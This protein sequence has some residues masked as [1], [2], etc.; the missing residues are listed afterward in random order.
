MR[1]IL[2]SW[3]SE[4]FE[5]LQDITHFHPDNFEK[6]Q[7]I[8]ALK[9]NNIQP[10]PL[11]QQISMMKLRA[12]FNTHRTPEI[13]IFTTEDDVEFKHV[14]DWMIAD[15]QSLVDWVRENHWNKILSDYN[16]KKR[17]VIE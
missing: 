17:K 5:C 2:A 11:G 10:N 15:P 9:G 6:G 1:Y 13:Y 16:P 8:D 7:L 3:D 14:E 4:G 12:R